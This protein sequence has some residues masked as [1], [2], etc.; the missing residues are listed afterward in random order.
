VEGEDLKKFPD[1]FDSDITNFGF[2]EDAAELA[3]GGKRDQP[4]EIL[5]VNVLLVRLFDLPH[6]SIELVGFPSIIF[7]ELKHPIPG[8]FAA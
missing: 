8:T 4:A 1:F 5:A 3:G 2:G 7:E 6:Q